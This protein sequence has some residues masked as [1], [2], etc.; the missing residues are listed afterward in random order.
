MSLSY[1]LFKAGP[2]WCFLCPKGP[3]SE[4]L[5]CE[6]SAPWT[7]AVPHH[8]Q[9]T[10]GEH[11]GQSLSSR[12]RTAGYCETGVALKKAGLK[13]QAGLEIE[14]GIEKAGFEIEPGLEKAVFE[15]EV[16]LDK[17]GY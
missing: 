14:H 17:T 6:I 13:I 15:I 5:L 2:Q 1:R 12:L 7:A 16:G 10:E 4:G 11:H 3:D 8:E 9:Q